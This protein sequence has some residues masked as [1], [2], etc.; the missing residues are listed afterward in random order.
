MLSTSDTRSRFEVRSTDGTQIAVF[1]HGDG[2]PI[3]L[4]HGALS[5]HT[6]LDP[7]AEALQP[8]N[9]TYQVDRRGRG[10]SG[11]GPAYAIEREF[12]DVAAVVDEVA[13]RR[14]RHVALFGHSYGADCAMGAAALTR[15]V[16]HLIL[17]EPGLAF[18]FRPGSIEAVE[19]AVAAGDRE[20]AMLAMLVGVVEATDE[21]ISA[22]RASP[23]WQRRLEFVGTVPRELY[24]TRDWEYVPGSLDGVTAPTLILAGSESPSPQDEA[25]HRAAR[26]IRHARI[27]TLDGHGHFAIQ[28]DPALVARVIRSFIA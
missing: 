1:A 23:I 28:T 20:A 9:S 3:V 14:G 2:P 19:L 6:R 18:R 8:G 24:A 21:E 12:E 15:N 7:V 13:A 16:G 22:M 11:D 27:E 17:Y 4:V 25:T 10:A 26:A 5:D